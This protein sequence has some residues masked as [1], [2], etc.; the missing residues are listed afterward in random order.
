MLQEKMSLMPNLYQEIIFYHNHVQI[1]TF[2]LDNQQFK[3]NLL[4]KKLFFHQIN[5]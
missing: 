4:E 2:N 3:M 5:K 1:I